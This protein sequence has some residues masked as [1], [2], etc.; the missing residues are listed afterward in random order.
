M[1]E[2]KIMQYLNSSD[3]KIWFPKYYGLYE[4]TIGYLLLSEWIDGLPIDKFTVNL[5][6]SAD[7]KDYIIV[8]TIKQLFKFIRWFHW[9]GFVHGDLNPNNIIVDEYNNIKIIDFGL[10]CGDVK[11]TQ[12]AI[13]CLKFPDLRYNRNVDDLKLRD[14]IR[15]KAI[16]TA[17]IY[18]SCHRPLTDNFQLIQREISDIKPSHGYDA[19]MYALQQVLRF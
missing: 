6:K 7:C 17:L 11:R 14:L 13:D 8:N 5:T 18:A 3:G 15:L 1:G 9:E 16:A 10:S 19:I 12:V 2:D 4:T